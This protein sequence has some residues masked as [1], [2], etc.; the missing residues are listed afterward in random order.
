VARVLVIED[1]ASVRAIIRRMLL[2]GGHEVIEAATAHTGFEAAWAGRVD[3]VIADVCLGEGDGIGVIADIRRV[4]P[5]VS[6][7]VVSG[8]DRNEIQV[9]LAAAELRHSVWLLT[10]PFLHEQL[11]AAVR[12]ALAQ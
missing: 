12:E 9:R 2:E 5:E 8:R 7:I 3:V 4:Q 6:L 11:L 1:E 10:K